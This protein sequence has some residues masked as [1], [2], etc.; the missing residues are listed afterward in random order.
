MSAIGL[1]RQARRADRPAA[2]IVGEG[3]LLLCG[4][5]FLMMIGGIL[6]FQATTPAEEFAARRL[7]GQIFGCRLAGGL[8]LFSLLGMVRALFTH[9]ATM[10]PP[11]A[12][13]LVLALLW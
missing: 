9:L 13:I 1:W 11:A 6:A 3:N 5:L 4:V 10:A 8:M 12:L 7:A 2:V